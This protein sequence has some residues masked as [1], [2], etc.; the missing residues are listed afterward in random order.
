MKKEI[1]I[2]WIGFVLICILTIILSN[3]SCVKFVP[4][5][6]EGLPFDE[7]NVT[8]GFDGKPLKLPEPTY[9]N[10]FGS[11][12]GCSTLCIILSLFKKIFL[13]I[14]GNAVAL[15]QMLSVCFLPSIR[16]YLEELVR[17]Y[18]CAI[19]AVHGRYEAMP[20]CFIV[21]GLCIV[22]FVYSLLMTLTRIRYKN[23]K[24]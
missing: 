15:F 7:N 13:N 5:Y 6:F 1:N 12:V 20:M 4:K 24:L 14:A 9:Y 17:P 21:G 18:G 19:G 11:V 16:D 10:A 23:S 2:L 22:M 8:Y 3:F